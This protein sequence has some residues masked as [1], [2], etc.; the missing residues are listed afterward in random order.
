MKTREASRLADPGAVSDPADDDVATGADIVGNEGA[1]VV[2]GAEGL[3]V[4]QP[5]RATATSN[6]AIRLIRTKSD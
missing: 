2:G 5:V 6:P 3:L 1:A 4:P